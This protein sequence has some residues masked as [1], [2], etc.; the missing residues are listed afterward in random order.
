MTSPTVLLCDDAEG[1]RVMLG[2]LLSEAGF[3][4][5]LGC[6]WDDAVRCATE[7]RPD[8]IVVDL[9][10]PTYDA[11]RLRGLRACSPRSVVVVISALSTERSRLA[12]AGIDGISAVVS[13]RDRPQIVVAAV[14]DA[15]SETTRRAPLVS[16]RLP[17][18]TTAEVRRGD[19]EPSIERLRDEAAQAA[20]RLALYRHKAL[21]GGG[22]HRVLARRQ[23]FARA[24]TDR[25]LRA[26][27]GPPSP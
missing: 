10:M 5:S 24:A 3:D 27:Q 20:E 14:A 19:R 23:R 16:D 15:L 12:V 4:V 25:L 11:T 2:T 9:W 7:R 26:G 22:D 6:T 17:P 8:A 13:K 18:A 1:F 21:L